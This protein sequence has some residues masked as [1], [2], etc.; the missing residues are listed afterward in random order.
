MVAVE[1]QTAAKQ[2]EDVLIRVNSALEARVDARTAAL[3][4]AVDA[5]AH[6]RGWSVCGRK[7]SFARRRRWRRWVSLLAGSRMTSTTCSR[8]SDALWR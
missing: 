1:D 3:A 2:A 5:V 4:Q 6:R 7:S 8:V